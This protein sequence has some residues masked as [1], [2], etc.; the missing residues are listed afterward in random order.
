MDLL[1]LVHGLGSIGLFSS[2]IFLPALVTSLILRFGPDVPVIHSWGLLSH[3]QHHEPTWFTNNITITVLAILSA[4]EIFGQK[5]PELRTL[6]HEF[7]MYL[8]PALAALTSFGVIKTSDAQFV[9][10]ATQAGFT[11][12]IIPLLVALGTWRVARVRNQVMMEI[13]AH[14]EGTHLDHFLGWLEELW[15]TFGAL[16]LVLIPI[17]MLIM[18][19]IATGALYL[20][21]RRLR[22]LEEQ[23]KIACTRCGKPVYPSAMACPACRQ[24][25]AMPAEVG[26]LGQSKPYPCAD[27]AS[28]PYRLIEKRRC[29]VCA[30]HLPV[31]KPFAPCPACAEAS[32]ADSKFVDGYLAYVD[33]R[34]PIVLGVCFLLSLIPILGLIAGAVYYRISLVLP[35]S[36]Y[37]P[38][39]R[40]FLLRWLIRFVFLALIFVQVV[41]VLGGFVVPLLAFM[42]FTAYRNGFASMMRSQRQSEPV[43]QIPAA[44]TA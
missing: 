25:L 8:K 28:Q 44:G 18:I 41:P 7:D 5:N 2:R 11:D 37:L 39:G 20:M 3:L 19:G 17:F 24:P 16:L 40:R 27:L 42:N 9:Q 15:V 29:A 21:R 43:A 14:V 35:F 1:S 26:F 23:S 4:L 36:Q 33:R 10:H 22:R 38:F 13:F 30:S 12:G 34:L 6:L 32:L 31:R